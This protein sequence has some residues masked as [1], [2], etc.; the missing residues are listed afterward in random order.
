LVAISWCSATT[1]AN[2]STST[3]RTTHG[4]PEEQAARL[5]TYALRLLVDPRTLHDHGR[6]I[7][8]IDTLGTYLR[9]IDSPCRVVLLL[10][11]QTAGEFEDEYRFMGEI[12]VEVLPTARIVTPVARVG[13]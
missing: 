2:S 11:A 6:A 5:L 8:D 10:P 12:G 4:R 3:S 7:R 9:A 1:A 13:Q